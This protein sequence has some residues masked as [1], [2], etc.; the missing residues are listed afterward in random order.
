MPIKPD[1]AFDEQTSP[2]YLENKKTCDEFESFVLEKNGQTKG[3]YNTWSYI[4]TGKIPHD[5]QWYITIKKTTLTSG[6]LILSS[7][8]QSLKYYGRWSAKNFTSEC[9]SF[10]IAKSKSSDFILNSKA[11]EI[12]TNKAY[13]IT[14]I[15]NKHKLILELLTIL[16]TLFS[17]NEI[18]EIV[19]SN[20]ELTIDYRS[21]NTYFSTI[22]KIL[23]L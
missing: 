11:K 14:C 18:W 4:A 20:N 21:V 7:D 6:N 12:T 13:S 10:K 9:P 5:K 1:A 3:K 19:Y 8:Y 16:E 15:N 17:L 23:K 22:D 2:F